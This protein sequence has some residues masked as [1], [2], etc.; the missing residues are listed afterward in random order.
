[1]KSKQYG[2]HYC[3]YQSGLLEKS[4]SEGHQNKEDPLKPLL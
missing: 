3:G 2:S 1:M 4:R